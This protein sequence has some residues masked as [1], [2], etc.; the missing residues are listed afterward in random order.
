MS[1]NNGRPWRVVQWATGAVGK[2]TLRAVIEH[3]DLELV[4][5]YVYSDRKVGRDAGEIARRDPTG[6]IATNNIDDI[7]ALDADVVLH[8][9]RVGIPYESQD[10]DLIALL[11]SGKNVITTLGQH[12]PKAHGPEREAMFVEAAKR[13]NSTLFGAGINPGFVLERLALT[14]T[15]MCLRVDSISIREVVDASGMPDPGFV[16]GVM[17]MG[18]DPA[19][20]EMLTGSFAE[21]YNKLFSEAIHY[22]ADKIGV[23]IERIEPDHQ[24]FP[25]SRRLEIR[26]G[27]IEEGTVAGTNWRWH[28][29]VDGKRFLTLSINWIMD[30][31][32][33]GFADP[34]LW[35]VSITG[36]PGIEIAIDVTEP[37]ENPDGRKTR[38]EQYATAGPV[39]A[40]IPFVC[41]AAPGVFELPTLMPWHPNLDAS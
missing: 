7:L 24:L 3:P 29:I 4:G 14:A 10:A 27:V 39:I 9:A 23:N 36:E 33:P 19:S 25:A 28:A 37:P 21:L 41:Q 12:Y 32:L 30:P 2:T 17:G 15:G 34:H 26:A 8:T 35:T 5:L 22:T 11:E 1:G 18:T 38:A 13:G 16:F 6:V 20:P 40:A 31:D